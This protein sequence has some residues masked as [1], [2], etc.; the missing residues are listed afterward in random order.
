MPWDVCRVLAER[1][2]ES[3]DWKTV[4]QPGKR[5][6]ESDEGGGHE[7]ELMTKEQLWRWERRSESGARPA[8]NILPSPLVSRVRS[9]C[10][11]CVVDREERD[12]LKQLC[13]AENQ[14]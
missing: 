2:A 7:K 9:S 5:P 6:I 12:D 10:H 3:L 14:R 1:D 13:W 8:G 4:R 11:S